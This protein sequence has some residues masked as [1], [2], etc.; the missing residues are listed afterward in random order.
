MERRNFLKSAFALTAA[1]AVEPLLTTSAAAAELPKIS[2]PSPRSF[3]QGF[4]WG[5]ATA[6]YQVEG[7]VHDDGR[8][9][10]MWDTFRHTPGKTCH[11]ETGDVADD[12]FHLYKQDVALMKELGT[13]PSA[14]PSPGRAS[15]RKARARPIP[16]ASTFTSASSMNCRPPASSLTPRSSTGICPRP[17]RTRVAG[18][19]APQPRLSPT[20]PATPPA[21]SPT[22]SLTG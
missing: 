18:P 22:A 20:T 6:A 9:P 12:F 2:V 13:R 16:K 4:L 1:S 3:P 21:S 10:S 5:T 8:G 14:S 11:G 7:A 19:A 15:S 17:S